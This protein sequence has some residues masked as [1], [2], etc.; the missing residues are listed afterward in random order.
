MTNSPYTNKCAYHHHWGESFFGLA[1]LT[2]IGVTINVSSRATWTIRTFYHGLQ[3][4]RHKLY[5]RSLN[6]YWVHQKYPLF[7]W[8]RT[9]VLYWERSL[10][11]MFTGSFSSKKSS[12]RWYSLRML[13]KVEKAV[14]L[15]F[16]MAWTHG[17]CIMVTAQRSIQNHVVC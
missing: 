9:N 10:F 14:S 17:L 6:Y 3:P 8:G 12:F 2:W 11:K 1:E 5:V 16:L 13:R 4:S 15:L 7:V